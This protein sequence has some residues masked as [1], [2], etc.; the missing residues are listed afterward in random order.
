MALK[1]CVSGAWQDISNLKHYS[2]SAWQEA[3]SANK[4]INSAWQE[5][6]GNN[7]YLVKDTI[8]NTDYIKNTLYETEGYSGY[9]GTLNNVQSGAFSYTIYGE[10]WED[11][12]GYVDENWVNFN[13]YI[14]ESIRTTNITNLLALDVSKYTTIAIEYTFHDYYAGYECEYNDSG[15]TIALKNSNT[16]VESTKRFDLSETKYGESTIITCD[17]TNYDR[18]NY[19]YFSF[20]FNNAYVCFKINNIYLS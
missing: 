11:E 6:W 16:Y 9:W 3:Q 20:E 5:V 15:L 8:P 1:D 17:L 12:D 18:L 4:Y 10:D 19:L 14:V 13:L 7:L 2:S